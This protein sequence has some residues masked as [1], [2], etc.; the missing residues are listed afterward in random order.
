MFKTELYRIFSRKTAVLAMLLAMF[1]TIF[2]SV[3]NSY[4][5]EAVV[6]GGVVYQHG[7]AIQRDKEIAAEFSGPLTEEK[8]SAIWEKYGA[9]GINHIT[10][11]E[12]L[13]EL[14]QN[15]VNDNFCNRFVAR[16]F[17]KEVT[18]ETGNITFVLRD[19]LSESPFL[20]GSY[21]FG[22]TGEGWQW[23]SDTFLLFW[24]MVCLVILIAL[25]PTFS[26]DYS[27]RTADIILP[28]AKGRFPL[29]RTRLGAGWCFATLFYWT[30]GIL[31][32]A[33]QWSFYGL[34]GL[35]VSSDLAGQFLYGETP[36]LWAAI[37]MM[38]FGGYLALS[39]LVAMAMAVSVF[40][41]HTFLSLVWC[42]AF[43]LGPFALMRILLDQLPGTLLNVLL[44]RIIYGLPLSF[45]L[46]ILNAPPVQ[47]WF[48]LG[49][50][51]VLMVVCV[52]SGILG[53]CRH[54][55]G[56]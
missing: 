24:I 7:A 17:C 42:L 20:Q 13:L 15:G 52:F 46:V 30:S 3:M 28:T 54:Q 53:W 36:P 11:E 10:T 32:F 8:V 41:R 47:R 45:A 43:Y 16:L 26:D 18:D 50:E 49:V 21:I 25:C 27:L 5:S 31:L 40:C 37:A 23:F 12:H 22:Y 1:L 55:V 19:D 48:L 2:Y 33:E 29:W 39:V 6:D 56:R 35:R 38:Y 44:H 9:P 34:E 14:A 4:G 51:G